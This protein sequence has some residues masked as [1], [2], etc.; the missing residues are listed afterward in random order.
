MDY[1]L[2]RS[3]FIYRDVSVEEALKHTKIVDF[4][5]KD[6]LDKERVHRI[7]NSFYT[8]IRKTFNKRNVK[9]MKFDEKVEL[10]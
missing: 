4:I 1:Y 10:L 6:N 2:E 3:E 7:Q 8:G 5:C 9:D